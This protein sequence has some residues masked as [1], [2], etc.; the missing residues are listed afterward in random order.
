MKQE[1]IEI[2]YSY[3]DGSGHRKVVVVRPFS[4]SLVLD[5]SR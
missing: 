5:G 3:W 1:A 2:T 4:L